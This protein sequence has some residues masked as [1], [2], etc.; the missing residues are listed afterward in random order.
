VA[1]AGERTRQAGERIARES[2]RLGAGTARLPRGRGR[3]GSGAQP[4]GGGPGGGGLRGALLGIA[5]FRDCFS[6]RGQPGDQQQRRERRVCGEV[7]ERGD[8]PGGA[9]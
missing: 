5:Q 4:L 7:G 1:A 8:E 6:Q 9:A 2:G 3:G